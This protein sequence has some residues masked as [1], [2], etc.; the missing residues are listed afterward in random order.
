MLLCYG[1]MPR[2][3]LVYLLA[4]LLTPFLAFDLR[5]Y[6]VCLFHCSIGNLGYWSIIYFSRPRAEYVM[7]WGGVGGYTAFIPYWTW[8]H[9][10]CVRALYA[11][12]I[13]KYAM[14]TGS[15]YSDLAAAQTAHSEHRLSV[16]PSS[17][18]SAEWLPCGVCT[19]LKLFA[20]FCQ[21]VG[22]QV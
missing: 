12:L 10:T 14:D 22:W 15:S 8:M 13:R 4:D 5:S 17:Q 11:G 9:T 21:L 3:S 7:G 20:Y 1:V 16:Y 18:A 19:D 2:L 6:F